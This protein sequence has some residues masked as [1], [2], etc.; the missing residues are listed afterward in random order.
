MSKVREEWG[1]WN[2][3]DPFYSDD[4]DDKKEKKGYAEK[5]RQHVDFSHA[6]YR[7]VSVDSFPDSS[8]QADEE[9]TYAFIDE[10]QALV[11]RVL[12]GIYA[13]YGF[14]T[15]K[16]NEDLMT[17]IEKAERDKLWQIYVEGVTE[18]DDKVGIASINK[19]GWD[20]IQRKLLH[21]MMTNDEFYYVLGGHSA[22][23]GH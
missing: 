13:E 9:Y 11:N 3:S 4:D 19:A 10:A 23:A 18:G 5:K 22:A 21:A 8:W 17:E 1:A 2:L 14:P 16:E 6:P 12:E 7:D 20:L 15:K